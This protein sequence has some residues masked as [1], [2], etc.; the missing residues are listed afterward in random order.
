[1]AASIQKS[2]RKFKDKP[3]SVDEYLLCVPKRALSSFATLRQSVKA[4]V[5]TDAIEV[6]SYGILALKRKKVLVWFGAFE[7]HCSLF[8]TAAVIEEFKE[9]LNG[10]VVSKG[11]VQ[12]SLDKPIPVALVRKLVKTRVAQAKIQK[13]T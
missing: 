9:E 7:N 10:F 2:S 6:L 11:T 3:K 4:A 1:M 5:P 12:F 8:P 13:R